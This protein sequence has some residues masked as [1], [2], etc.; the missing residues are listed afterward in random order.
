MFPSRGITFLNFAG[1]RT[2]ISVGS[3]ILLFFIYSLVIRPTIICNSSQISV[4]VPFLCRINHF[5]FPNEIRDY[6]C[7]GFQK[8]PGISLTILEGINH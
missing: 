5:L 2:G 8:Q 3:F 6:H 4:F 7:D 1:S